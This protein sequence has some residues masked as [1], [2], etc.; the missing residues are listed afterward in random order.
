VQVCCIF[1]LILL[2]YVTWNFMDSSKNLLFLSCKT[3]SVILLAYTTNSSQKDLRY[4]ILQML[5]MMWLGWQ[6]LWGLR[7]SQQ[8]LKL[9]PAEVQTWHHRGQIFRK[10]VSSL[11]N[12][13]I[14]FCAVSIRRDTDFATA[15][16]C[17]L[18]NSHHHCACSILTCRWMLML[19]RNL[20]PPSSRFK[21]TIYKTMAS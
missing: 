13:V 11:C 7:L 18:I 16:K 15:V 6:E 20:L 1:L 9:L 14:C 10:H 5:H 4:L 17:D 3:L 12:T 8:S 19:W 21:C 2:L